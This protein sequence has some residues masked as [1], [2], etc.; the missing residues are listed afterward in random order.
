MQIKLPDNMLKI[1][2]DHSQFFRL[3]IYGRYY[4]VKYEPKH[5]TPYVAWWD[6]KPDIEV[7]DNTPEEALMKIQVRH[8]KN[9][10]GALVY[11]YNDDYPALYKIDGVA[12]WDPQ[13][14]EVRW[15]IRL[16]ADGVVGDDDEPYL[17]RDSDITADIME[18]AQH[19]EDMAEEAAA[20]END[21]LPD[22][23]PDSDPYD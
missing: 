17:V 10:F 1:E 9:D 21:L 5:Y 23:S 7:E 2:L 12:V 4:I 11:W 8:F 18:W 13:T 16:L 14:L 6:E 3:R 15:L 20:Y 22:Q 19:Q